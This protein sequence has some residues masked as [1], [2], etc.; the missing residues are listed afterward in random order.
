[1]IA[2]RRIDFLLIAPASPRVFGK[3]LTPE[4]GNF[5][6]LVPEEAI[7][8]EV[9]HAELRELSQLPRHLHAITVMPLMA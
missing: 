5:N 9:I 8:E 2:D 3:A 1:M 4:R 6:A 7:L